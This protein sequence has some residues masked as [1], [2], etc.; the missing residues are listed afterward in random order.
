MCL[1]VF[2]FSYLVIVAEI[3]ISEKI[4][5]I[6]VGFRVADNLALCQQVIGCMVNDK[7]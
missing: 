5:G 3:G 4:A 6:W 7:W 2:K 1:N